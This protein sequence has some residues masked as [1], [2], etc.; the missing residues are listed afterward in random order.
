M[1]NVK[2]EF[3]SAIHLEDSVAATRKMTRGDLLTVM[4]EAYLKKRIVV[5]G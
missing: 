2:F 1:R 4:A 5:S 3:Q